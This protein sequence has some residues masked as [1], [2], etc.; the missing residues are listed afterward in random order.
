MR[1]SPLRIWEAVPNR[2]CKLLEQWHSRWMWH[3]ACR[4]WRGTGT[5][6]VVR[7][8]APRGVRDTALG[9]GP[10][11][12]WSEAPRASAAGRRRRSLRSVTDVSV[13]GD[14]R[15]IGDSLHECQVPT[16]AVMTGPFAVILPCDGVF[17]APVPAPPGCG[18]PCAR[19]G[20]SVSPRGLPHICA[21]CTQGG[22]CFGI[23]NAVNLKHQFLVHQLVLVTTLETIVKRFYSQ[24]VLW[25]SLYFF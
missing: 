13:P 15:V 2:S 10:D 14:T 5:L 20:R 22:T 7:R 25:K 19:P 1:D 17:L 6:A 24:R 12:P 11:G 23:Y 21:P 3:A 4:C 9:V 18:V 16:R 8:S